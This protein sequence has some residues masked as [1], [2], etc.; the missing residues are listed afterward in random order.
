[1]LSR[2]ERNTELSAELAFAAIPALTEHYAQKCEQLF[3]LAARPL[4]GPQRAQFR[5]LLAQALQTGFEASAHAKVVVRYR[6]DPPPSMSLSY[7]IGVQGRDIADVYAGWLR[8]PSEAHFGAHPDAKVMAVAAELPSKGRALDIGAG[9][10]R[11]SLPLARLGFEVDAIDMTPGFVLALRDAAAAQQSTV[12]AIEG[13][14]YDAQLDL[15]DAGYSLIVA[16]EVVSSHVRDV[17]ELSEFFDLA[18]RKL[19]PGGKLVCNVFLAVDGYEPDALARQLS[20]SLL[21]AVFSPSELQRAHQSLPLALLSNESCAGY[22]REHLPSAAWPPTSWFESWSRGG[23]LFDLGGART[24]CELR[25]LV[26]E[27]APATS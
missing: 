14:V 27:R 18:A 12:R 5:A 26:F 16:S 1:M 23:N 22:E 21:S 25:W 7:E 9:T 20:P 13:D 10:G 11:N 6:T 3:D 24:P 2:V 17:D 8:G 4:L 19:A 15:P